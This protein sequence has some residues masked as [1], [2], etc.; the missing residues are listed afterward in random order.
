M[1]LDL[2]K[3]ENVVNHGKKTTARCPA[4]AENGM[5][6]KG[7]HLC[8]QSD[9][10][11]GC[12]MHQGESGRDHR[13]R[14]FALAGAKEKMNMEFKIHPPSP[15]SG[16]GLTVLLEDVL[17]RLGRLELSH[18]RNALKKATIENAKKNFQNTIPSVPKPTPSLPCQAF[19]IRDLIR[20]RENIGGM[21]IPGNGGGV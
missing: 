17:G 21:E 9:G 19:D 6:R 16:A 8:I 10:R 13:R 2:A 12:V 11:F 15:S 20:K 18:A 14:I 5:D 7:D 1:R 3:L 4:C